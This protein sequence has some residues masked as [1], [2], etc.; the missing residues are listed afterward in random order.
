MHLLPK[1]EDQVLPIDNISADF[2]RRDSEYTPGGVLE[3]QD[4]VLGPSV[5]IEIDVL[6]YNS[7]EG[8]RVY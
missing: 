8:A 3:A 6:T 2:W 7:K 5:L 1:K 4:L